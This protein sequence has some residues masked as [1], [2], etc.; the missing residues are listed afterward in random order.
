MRLSV[1]KAAYADLSRVA[2]R[3]SGSVL[4]EPSSHANAD[5]RQLLLDKHRL[6]SLASKTH[7]VEITTGVI[8][9]VGSRLT[10]LELQIM[11]TLWTQ[12]EASIRQMRESFP[13]K[14]LKGEKP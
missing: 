5:K 10:K 1:K 3:K 9:M 12:G 7:V 6:P 2:S 8:D 11:E 13:E 14:T 4:G